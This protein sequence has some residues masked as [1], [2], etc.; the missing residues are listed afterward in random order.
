MP[1]LAEQPIHL[2]RGGAAAVEPKFDG[3]QWYE[4]YSARH[5]ADGAEGRLVSWYTFAESWG[6]WEMHPAGDEIVICL[7][8]AITLLQEMADGAVE[9]TALG[10]GDYAINPPGV[11]HTADV[12]AE[13]TAL[14][15][16]PGEGTQ[17]RPR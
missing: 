16:T 9:R 8:G 4:D 10:P 6:G 5:A 3:M 17:H 7:A 2:G 15:I 14:F 13:C 12:E 11:W 1:S